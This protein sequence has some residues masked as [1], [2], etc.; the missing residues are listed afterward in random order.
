[1]LDYDDDFNAA[2]VIAAGGESILPPVFPKPN[3]FVCDEVISC[4][5]VDQNAMY[6]A[7]Q[8]QPSSFNV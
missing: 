5:H 8:L 1:M 3:E 7:M 2:V 6:V 4:Y